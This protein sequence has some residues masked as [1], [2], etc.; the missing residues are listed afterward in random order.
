MASS[1]QSLMTSLFLFFSLLTLCCYSATIPF[2]MPTR[3]TAIH[4]PVRKNDTTRL[5]YISYEMQGPDQPITTVD[6][7]IDL[8]GPSVWMDCRSYVSSSYKRVSC[9]SD[10]CKKAYGYSICIECDR[11]PHPD[12][13]RGC[14]NTTCAVS[15]FYDFQQ[16]GVDTLKVLSTDGRSIYYDYEVPK[17][18]FSC[19]YDDFAIR[20][21]P[22]DHT[23]GLVGFARSNISLASQISSKFKLA[24][25]FAL[26][27]PST[28]N[29]LGSIFIG[30]GPYYMPPRIEDQ[31]L[32]FVTTP[33]VVNPVYYDLHHYPIYIDRPSDEHF[34]NVKDIEVRGKRVSF[35]SSLLSFKKDGSGGTKINIVEPFTRL[36][37]SIYKQLVKDFIKATTKNNIKMVKS[38]APFEACFDSKTTPKTITGP[39]VPDIDI[40]LEGNNVRFRLYGSSSMVEAK[41]DVICLA[42]IDGGELMRTSIVLDRLLEFDLGASKLGFT[43]SLLVSNTSCSQSRLF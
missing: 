25:K 41:K 18:Q 13:K 27:I 34:I 21:L 9:G 15:G 20:D 8:S 36:H 10:I 2:K 1:S 4:F 42:F 43:S 40:V 23:K 30:G 33:L 29:S 32:S 38:V 24:N 37:S 14:S 11:L 26:C 35:N 12:P 3:E 5:Y 39:A 6:A 31:S 22:G 19:S 16:L 7:L 28:E 17:F